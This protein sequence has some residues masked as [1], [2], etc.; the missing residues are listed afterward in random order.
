MDRK[1]WTCD[2]MG[3]GRGCDR[4]ELGLGQELAM[5]RCE[6]CGEKAVWVTDCG[7]GVT[8]WCDACRLECEAEAD[9]GG[10]AP[11]GFWRITEVARS[12]E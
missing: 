7:G 1:W 6:G 2:L 3:V 8:C 11:V 12:G 5:D 4:G 9:A 10:P